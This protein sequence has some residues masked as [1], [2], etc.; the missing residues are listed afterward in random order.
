[1]FKMRFDAFGTYILSFNGFEKRLYR[2][3][4]AK[5]TLKQKV[6]YFTTIL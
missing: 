6:D 5:L 2:L 3:F 4:G 1:M